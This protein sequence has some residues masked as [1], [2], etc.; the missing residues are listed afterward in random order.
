MA[1][2]PVI[3]DTNLLLLLV[4]GETDKAMVDRHRRLQIY[5]LEDFVWVRQQVNA[6]AG[7][8]LCP[9]IITETSNLIRYSSNRDAIAIAELFKIVVGQFDETYVPST[10]A[11]QR[12]EHGRLGV[13]D[14][15]LLI[16]A[17][18]M[19]QLITDDLDLALAA[20]RAGADV[21]NYNHI[22]DNR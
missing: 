8:I 4:V 10:S 12:Q 15:V 13:T 3:L 9:N 14:S 1:R 18:S 17:N 5:T 2:K 22:R 6:S 19:A 21:I 11:V 7:L 20:D 16:L